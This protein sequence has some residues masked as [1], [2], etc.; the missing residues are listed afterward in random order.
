VG[1]KKRYFGTQAFLH[2]AM[3]D[4]GSH[5]LVGCINLCETARSYGDGDSLCGR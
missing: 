1:L 2:S 4:H 3:A 5:R